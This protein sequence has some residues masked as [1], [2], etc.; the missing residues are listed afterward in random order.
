M[1]FLGRREAISAP[2]VG[3]TSDSMPI[4]AAMSGTQSSMLIISRASYVRISSKRAS[5]MSATHAA[6]SDHAKRVAAWLLIPVTLTGATSLL[7]VVSLK[8]GSPR[9]LPRGSGDKVYEETNDRELS[10]TSPPLAIPLHQYTN[11]N[12]CR[13]A[14]RLGSSPDPYWPPFLARSRPLNPR[15]QKRCV[16]AFEQFER[17]VRCSL[18]EKEENVQRADRRR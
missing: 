16:P 4:G 10:G 6:H 18:W 12:R 15:S 9:R 14:N 17:M 5:A 13:L 7:R 3:Y 8:P 1:G 2:I 11:C